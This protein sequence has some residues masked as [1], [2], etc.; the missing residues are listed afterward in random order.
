MKILV[1]EDDKDINNLI[2][3]ILLKEGYDVDA[4]YSGTEALL[5]FQMDHYD[6]MISDLMIPGL[7][8]EE[9]ISQIRQKDT[10]PIIVLT[11]KGDIDDKINVLGLG[12]DD[13]MTKPFEA[14]EL[15]ARVQVHLRRCQMNQNRINSSSIKFRDI[16]MLPQSNCVTV[17]GTEIKLT[18][19]EFLILKVMM[20]HPQKVYSKEALYQAVWNNGY[21][22][23]DNTISVHISNIRKKLAAV[24]DHEYISTVWGIGFK[25]NM[26]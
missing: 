18:A 13:Y 25:L 16:E 6:L 26:E 10:L 24:S 3:K 20:E 4:A 7:S 17:H 1:V 22:G 11:A 14:R 12:A 8:G 21:Y 19:H 9:M 23:E 5:R 2:Q 15:V